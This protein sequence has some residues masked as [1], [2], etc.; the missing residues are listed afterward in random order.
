MLELYLLFL[1]ESLGDE[2]ADC[3]DNEDSMAMDSYVAE[4]KLEQ[5]RIMLEEIKE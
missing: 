2:V 5:I 1:A 3:Y 4:G